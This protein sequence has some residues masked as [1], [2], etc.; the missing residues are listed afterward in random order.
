MFRGVLTKAVAFALF[1]ESVLPENMNIISFDGPKK[2]ED[3]MG[4]FNKGFLFIR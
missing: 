2:E 3:L 1:K 4:L